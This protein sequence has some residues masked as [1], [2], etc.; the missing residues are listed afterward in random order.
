MLFLSTFSIMF[1]RLIYRTS[2]SKYILDISENYVNFFSTVMSAFPVNGTLLPV[3][4]V[5]RNFPLL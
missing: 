5:S 4:D 2:F 1:T 3:Y